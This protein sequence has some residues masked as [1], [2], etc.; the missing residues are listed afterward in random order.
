MQA[1]V[2][3]AS[4]VDCARIAADV[5]LFPV[6][7]IQGA[8]T[9]IG[10]GCVIG[11]E[12]PVVI[13]NCQL[14][15]N[16]KLKGGYFSGSVFF[17][18]AHMG[19]GAH[20]RAGTILE[21]E[22][23][24]AH[25]VGL[26]QTILQPFVTLGSLINFCDL[27]MA[28]G[29]SRKDHSEVG[30]S[31]IHFNFMPH[32]D[33]ATASLVGD[34]PSGVF[35]DKKPIFLGGQGGLVGPARIAYGSVIAAGGVCRKD[36]QKE[37]QLHVPAT[38]RAGTQDYELGVY[39]SVDRIVKNNLL[40]IGNMLAL[41]EWYRHVRS[42]FVRDEFDRAVLDG[43]LK[44]LDLVLAERIKRLG[45]LTDKVELSIQKVKNN[46][47]QKRLQSEWPNMKAQLEQFTFEAPGDFLQSL[48]EGGTYIETIQSLESGARETGRAWLQSIVDAAEQL[49]S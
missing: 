6:S 18:G 24:G 43:G 27:M 8:E 33:K 45:D 29:T 46:E 36:V 44:N 7:R 39:R 21:E 15:R 25:T 30:S 34:V 38:P 41:R 9:S 37:N 42:R 14:G 12:A 1:G 4:E 26:K 40:Y 35:L 31:Y 47:S 5:T 13:E 32:Q 22:A 16:V 3:I 11:A 28:G 49:W 48:P 19:S 2:V 10:P 17:D 23:N 20:V